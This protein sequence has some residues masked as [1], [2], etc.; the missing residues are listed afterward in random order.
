MVHDVQCTS[1]C[2]AACGH[3][4]R[5]G[6]NSHTRVSQPCA[7]VTPHPSRLCTNTFPKLLLPCS[8]PAVRVL[9]LYCNWRRQ[10]AT[11]RDNQHVALP[12]RTHWCDS[13]RQGA[14][15]PRPTFN[16]RVVGSSP[17]RPT[18]SNQGNRPGAIPGRLRLTT[19]LT[20]NRLPECALRGCSPTPAG[21]G[22]SLSKLGRVSRLT[23]KLTG[24][25]KQYSRMREVTLGI[26]LR[27]FSSQLQLTSRH[28]AG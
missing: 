28:E 26:L 18:T 5:T 6:T 1:V 13:W 9:Q 3:A 14:T 20:T 7:A 15:P 25:G 10:H 22:N 17:T 12:V 11:T 16:P 19:I 23:G 24:K 4:L 2:R 27:Q 8:F 21:Q